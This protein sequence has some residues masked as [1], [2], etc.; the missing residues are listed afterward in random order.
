MSSAPLVAPNLLAFVQTEFDPS[1]VRGCIEKFLD[2]HFD[3][4][5][6][7]MAEE[8]RRSVCLEISPP[9]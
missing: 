2:E 3:F 6:E 1:Y 5:E 4:V 8:E 9:A 7:R